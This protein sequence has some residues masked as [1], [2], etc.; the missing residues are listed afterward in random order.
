FLL[1]LSVPLLR[2]ICKMESQVNQ[3][4]YVNQARSRQAV[5]NHTQSSGA[6]LYHHPDLLLSPSKHPRQP[7]S[8]YRISPCPQTDQSH[9]IRKS[10]LPQTDQSQ[11]YRKSPC[12]QTDQSGNSGHTGSRRCSSPPESEQ[13]QNQGGGV[14]EARGPLTPLMR[15]LIEL[16][17]T[18]T[19][20][21]RAP[22]K[23]Q[24][25]YH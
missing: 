21:G 15:A 22:C 20:E 14:R 17:E 3:L 11:S 1:C 10:P 6:G 23:K 24:P 13:P 8:T 4:D 18:R 16:E 12:P 7:E 5:H 9:S 25:Q 2:V 19:T